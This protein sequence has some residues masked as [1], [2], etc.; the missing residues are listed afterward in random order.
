MTIAATLNLFH[1]RVRW[2]K[3]IWSR[4]IC[5]SPI[6][7]MKHFRKIPSQT[8]GYRHNRYSSKCKHNEMY[9]WKCIKELFGKS[10]CDIYKCILIQPKICEENEIKYFFFV[11]WLQIQ[12]I[13]EQSALFAF[14]KNWFHSTKWKWY[15]FFMNSEILPVKNNINEQP[16]HT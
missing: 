4:N 9:R 8:H 11:A 16:N 5:C 6:Q 1:L 10:S 13:Y 14:S 2:I 7:A 12:R 15:V 3:G